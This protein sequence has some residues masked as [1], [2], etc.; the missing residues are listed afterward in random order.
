MTTETVVGGTVKPPVAEVPLHWHA[1]FGVEDCDAAVETVKE[2]GGS[3]L[4]GPLDTPV[5]RITVI[6]D[7]DGA[8]FSLIYYAELELNL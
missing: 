3:I 2:K 7:P 5:G 4:N 1:Y 6:T 8:A